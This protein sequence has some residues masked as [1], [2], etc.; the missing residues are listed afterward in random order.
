MAYFEGQGKR[1]LGFQH[2]GVLVEET[3]AADENELREMGL[4]FGEGRSVSEAASDAAGYEVE[5]VGTAV[6]MPASALAAQAPAA[7]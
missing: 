6:V 1:I 7:P 2:D 3:V 4:D 5:V